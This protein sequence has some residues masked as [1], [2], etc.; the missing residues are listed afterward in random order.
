[1]TQKI[2]QTKSDMQAQNPGD[3]T[4]RVIFQVVPE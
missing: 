3:T 2:N 1:M 4:F